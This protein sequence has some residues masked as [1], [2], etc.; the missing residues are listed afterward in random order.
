MMMTPTIPLVIARAIFL[1]ALKIWLWFEHLDQT[2]RQ[3]TTD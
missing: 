1:L 2:D 3:T